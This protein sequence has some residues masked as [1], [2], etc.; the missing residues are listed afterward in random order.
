MTHRCHQAVESFSCLCVCGLAS[1]TFSGLCGDLYCLHAADGST[2]SQPTAH[3]SVEEVPEGKDC[4]Q[5]PAAGLQQTQIFL[6]SF[7]QP[8]RNP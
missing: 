1:V 6:L 2:C 8:E 4:A 5:S 7:L 3:C